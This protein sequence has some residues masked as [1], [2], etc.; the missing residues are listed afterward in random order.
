LAAIPI[1]AQLNIVLQLVAFG[2]ILVGVRYAIRTHN[3]YRLG[4]AE[5]DEKGQISEK[6]HKNL[7]TSAVL[8]SGLGVIIWMVP[9]FILGWFYGPGFPGYGSGGY[10]SYIELFGTYNPHWYLIPI[11]IG[12]GSAT[13]ALGVYLVLRM[14]WSGFP[15]ALAV[16][17]F[18]PVMITTWSLWVF[19]VSIGLLVYYFFAYL[20]TG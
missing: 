14:R 18:R 15:Q 5:G 10:T 20:G 3:A 12:V 2:L 17:N 7:M 16:K 1:G 4:T 19:N 8:V 11:M 9:N 13:S 6:T